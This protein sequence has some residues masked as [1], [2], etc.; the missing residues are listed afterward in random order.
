ML[1]PQCCLW[2]LNKSLETRTTHITDKKNKEKN[3]QKTESW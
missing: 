3:K 2:H 1:L